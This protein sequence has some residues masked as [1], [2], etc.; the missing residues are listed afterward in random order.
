MEV[1][2]LFD[3]FRRKM[4]VGPKSAGANPAPLLMERV[5]LISQQLMPM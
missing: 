3:R 2:A 4:R 5:V 1:E